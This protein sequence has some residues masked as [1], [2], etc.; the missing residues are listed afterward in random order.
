[1]SKARTRRGP[2]PGAGLRVAAELGIPEACAVLGDQLARK[3]SDEESLAWYVK[4]AESGHAP[5]MFA[6]A[7]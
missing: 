1:M 6:A 7:G 3:G 2:V 4:A 5:A